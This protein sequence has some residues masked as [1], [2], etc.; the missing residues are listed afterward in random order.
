MRTSCTVLE[1]R[2]SSISEQLEHGRAFHSQETKGQMFPYPLIHAIQ[3]AAEQQSSS[4]TKHIS[5]RHSPVNG[6]RASG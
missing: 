4:R 2:D 6:P 1:E 3:A 5:V